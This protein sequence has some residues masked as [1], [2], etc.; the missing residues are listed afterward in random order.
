MKLMTSFVLVCV[1]MTL[2]H[3]QAQVAVHEAPDKT[4]HSFHFNDE[5]FRVAFEVPAGW[6][7]TT[8]DGEVSSFHADLSEVPSKFV[9]RAV[10]SMNFNP[11]PQSTLGGAMFY[12]SVGQKTGEDAC[13]K[14]AFAEP[15][16]KIRKAAT[17]DIGGMKF[18]HAHDEGG[19]ICTEVRDEVYAAYRKGACYRFDLK[20]NTFCAVSSGAMEINEPELEDI[21]KRMVGILSTVELGWEKSGPH[22]VPVPPIPA[23]APT[24]KVP[25]MPVMP[26]RPGVVVGVG[27]F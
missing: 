26:Q 21:E 10:A 6:E 4:D 9:L 14:A 19:Q 27:Q 25:E 20:I 5:R 17:Q 15:Q 3:A 7:F 22:E 23:V 11:F 2:S 16:K 12:F 1:G 13:L 18:V 24:P 8:K